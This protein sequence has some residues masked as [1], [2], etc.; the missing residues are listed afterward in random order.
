MLDRTRDDKANSAA[1]V[2]LEPAE[3]LSAKAHKIRLD[4]QLKVCRNGCGYPCTAVEHE[5]ELNGEVPLD[6]T[7]PCPWCSGRGVIRAGL[8]CGICRGNGG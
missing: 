7:K 6:K 4:C 3:T 8:H 2:A 5:A 1:I